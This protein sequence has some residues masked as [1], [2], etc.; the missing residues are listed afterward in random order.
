MGKLVSKWP[1][2]QLRQLYI[3]VRLNVCI[4]LLIV[5]TSDMHFCFYAIYIKS[6]PTT[7]ALRGTMGC[8]RILKTNN[9]RT[10]SADCVQI[11]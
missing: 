9:R 7:D 2:M 10:G 6:W 11:S 4:C 5:S 3:G 1:L 8:T